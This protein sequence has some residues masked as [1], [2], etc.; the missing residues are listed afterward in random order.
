MS[1]LLYQVEN[2]V[3]T[4]TI[5]RVQR[6]NSLSMEAV[7]RFLECLNE[8]ENDPDVR[9]VLVTGAGER[10]FCTGADLGLSL[11]DGPGNPVQAFARLLK[12]LAGFPGPTVARVNGYC[13]AGGMGIMLACDIVIVR[14]DA[15]FGTP[16]VNLGLFPMMIGALLYRN[17]LP[18]HAMER[19]LL[20]Q[21]F[22]AEQALRMGMIT[23]VVPAAEFDEHVNDTLRQLVARSPIGMRIGKAA[24]YGM[25][26]M[27]F[28]EAVD[29]LA[30]RFVE[31]ASTEDAKEGITAFME[32]RQPVFKGK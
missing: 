12:R 19:V 16:E 7:M 32:K 18:K 5:N 6:R 1:D 21:R 25:A 13:L 8:A 4:L 10:A 9:V 28:E 30:D 23:R 27:P 2:H 3:A 17:A 14:E 31:I 29:Y 24:F 22:S 15:Q 11:G 26:D 20:G